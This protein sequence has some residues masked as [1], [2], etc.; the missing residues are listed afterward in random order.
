MNTGNSSTHILCLSGSLRKQS[1]NTAVL[2]ALARLAPDDIQCEIFS[3]A[4]QLPL[5]NPDREEENIPSVEDL[6]QAMA[7]ADALVIASPEYA[8]GISGVMKNTLDWLVGGDRFPGMPVA[9]I[10][11]SPRASHALMS[12]RE[13]VTTMSGVLVESACIAVPLL[14]TGLDTDGI[15]ADAK[16]SAPLLQLLAH[17]RTA[18]SVSITG[19]RA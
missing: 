19:S 8:H 11:T 5:F 10:N 1:Y 15:V 12:L 14:G 3:G 9:L 16:L 6:H 2:Q 13:V 17:L 18:V 4:G 7:R